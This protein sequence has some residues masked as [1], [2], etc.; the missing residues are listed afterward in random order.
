MGERRHPLA[1]V[2]QDRMAGI[3]LD[4]GFARVTDLAGRFGVS[5]VTVRAD[6]S[7]LEAR[8]RVRRVRGGAVPLGERERPFESSQWEAPVQKSSIG[9]RAAAMIADGD[10]VILDVGTTTTAIARALVLRTDLRDVTVVTNGLN[11]ALELEP[12]APR[13]SVVVTGGTLRPLQ[14][15]LVNPLGTVLLERLRASVAFV[16]CNGVDPEVGVT[17]VNLPEAEVK[18]AMLLAAR[19]RVI[20]ADGSKVGEV[21][22]AKVCDIEEVHLIITDPSADPE[23]LTEIAAAG[24]QVELAG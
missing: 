8:A 9:V 19:R 1:E 16:G 17:N 7:A 24:C 5:A 11:I 23:V 2:R 21:E 6:L 10:T 4:E 18:R 13:I 3:I 22:L 12:A 15:S 14:H 20:V